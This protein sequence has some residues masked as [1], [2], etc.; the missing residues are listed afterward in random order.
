MTSKL[1]TNNKTKMETRK[2][3]KSAA[4]AVITISLGL[5]SC[6]KK[7]EPTPTPEPAPDTE[8]TSANDNAMAENVASDIETMGAQASENSDLTTYRSSGVSSAEDLLG[9]AS[10]ATVMLAPQ[11]MTVDFGTSGCT[12]RDGKLRT[13]KLIFTLGSSTAKFYRNFGF[14]FNVTSQNYV[15][16]GYSI[17]IVNKTAS[18]I[19]PVNT[20]TVANPGTNL[21]WSI[22]ANISIV[23]P[24]GGGTVTWTCNRTK[25][26]L[27]TSDTACYNGQGKAI[28]WD[29]AIISLNGSASGTNAQGESYTVV[30]TN[31]VR[32]FNCSPRPLHPHFH[33]F[34][35][36]TILYTPGNRPARLIDYGSGCNDAATV[37][38][39]GQTFAI[40]AP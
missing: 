40:V 16:D 1:Q 10:C 35:S 3:I 9:G 26:L 39:N 12:G 11:S 4:I 15:V 32:D 2:I 18:N 29:K 30:A 13:G 34:V 36:G 8:Q 37:T 24:N 21:K 14:T 38:I 6:K 20:P 23:K 17:N 28:R 7:Q 5:V 33:P 22:S 27:N 19:T 25:E 31:L